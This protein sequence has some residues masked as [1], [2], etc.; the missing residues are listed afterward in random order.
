IYVQ[1]EAIGSKASGNDLVAQRVA[2]AAHLPASNSAV[3]AM[4]RSKWAESSFAV[5]WASKRQSV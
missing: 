2:R 5:P 3:R 1:Q 4:M